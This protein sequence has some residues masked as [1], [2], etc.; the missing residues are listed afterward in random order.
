MKKSIH[1]I[2][3]TP[4][5]NWHDYRQRQKQRKFAKIRKNFIDGFAALSTVVF[6]VSLFFF[7]GH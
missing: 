1:A 5:H 6:T 3:H 7:G 4:I 2:E